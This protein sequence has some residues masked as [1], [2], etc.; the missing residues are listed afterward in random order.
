MISKPLLKQSIKANGLLWIAAT[1]IVAIIIAILK[2]VM[3]TSSAATFT[4]NTEQLAPYIIALWKAGLSIGGLTS[5]LGLSEDFLQNMQNMDLNVV[6]NNLFYNLAGVLVPMIYAVIVANNLMASQVDRGAMS[7]ILSTPIKR[8]TVVFT[9]SVFLIVSLFLMFVV[10]AITD[11]AVSFAMQMETNVAVI[12]LLNLGLFCVMFAIGGICFMF[13]SIFNLSKYS[14]AASGGLCV[15]FYINKVLGM[16]G[17]PN[18]VNAGMGL[19]SMKVFDYMSIITLLDTASVSALTT[20]FI[21]KFAILVVV[22]LITFIV[23]NVV[24]VKKDLPL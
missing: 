1:V 6:M 19:A 11:I 8:S 10:S 7:F 20:D 5:T 13:A 18:F 12:V 23:G 16:F 14:Y 3:A 24:F 21:W 15:L 22:G 2:I 17:D 4:V 9:Q